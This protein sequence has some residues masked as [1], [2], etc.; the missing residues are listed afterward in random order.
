MNIPCSCIRPIEAT[1]HGVMH[2]KQAMT[3]GKIDLLL[4]FGDHTNFCTGTLTFE[5]VDFL[6]T[7][8]VILGQP[9]YAKFMTM[10]NY[11]YLMLKM[12]A[13]NDILSPS[14]PISCMHIYVSRSAAWWPP[15]S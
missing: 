14:G 9:Y 1:I 7:C 6:D 4:T 13:R 5:V 3:L 2:S 12:S 11:T 8:L 15:W 10:P